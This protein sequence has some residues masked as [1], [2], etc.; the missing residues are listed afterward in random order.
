SSSEQIRGG[1]VSCSWHSRSTK[2][3]RASLLK[4]NVSPSI[5]FQLPSCSLDAAGVREFRLAVTDVKSSTVRIGHHSNREPFRN[6]IASQSPA[7][8]HCNASPSSSKEAAT[9]D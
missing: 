3:A 4:S 7:A 8:V 9:N 2:A 1:I 6:N 5:K